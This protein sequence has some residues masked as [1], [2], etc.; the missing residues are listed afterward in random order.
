VNEVK[1]RSKTIRLT[2]VIP[3]TAILLA[4]LFNT[5][6]AQSFQDG[7]DAYDEGD[8]E[9]ALE[10]FQS[11]AEEG[12]D[13]ARFYLGFMYN[14]GLGVA[15]DDAEAVLWYRAAAEQGVA[16]AQ[17]NLAVMYSRG[18]GVTQDYITAHMWFNIASANGEQDGVEGRELVADQMSREAIEEAQGRARA[19]MESGYQDCN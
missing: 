15:E 2:T 1:M 3:A 12:N 5:A 6:W 8:Y 10:I 17:T 11:F 14:D 18:E 13:A 16:R 4:L 7:V 19:C 9:A